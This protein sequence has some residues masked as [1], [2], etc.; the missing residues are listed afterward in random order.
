M[1]EQKDAWKDICRNVSL[2]SPCSGV[3][4][5]KRVRYKHTKE[6]KHRWTDEW[7]NGR[8]GLQVMHRAVNSTLPLFKTRVWR[9]LKAQ[10][11]NRW[12]ASLPLLH[13][14]S[15]LASPASPMSGNCQQWI[16]NPDINTLSLIEQQFL[17]DVKLHRVAG[18]FRWFTPFCPHGVYQTNTPL[19]TV[20]LSWALKH[21]QRK[22]EREM[23]TWYQMETCR[24]L[25]NNKSIKTRGWRNDSE[26]IL[27]ALFAYCL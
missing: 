23:R 20:Y 7:M 8:Q 27:K 3:S 26:S 2:K 10:T 11:E 15:P 24:E 14:T 18:P 21:A 1:E 6:E 16:N 5:I 22:N 25:R 13:H 9:Q 4:H 12:S 17:W 19:V